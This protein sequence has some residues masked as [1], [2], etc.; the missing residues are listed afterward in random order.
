MNKQQ[1]STDGSTANRPNPYDMCGECGKRFCEVSPNCPH[2]IW[3]LHPL[4]ARENM[5]P[6]EPK[7]TILLTVKTAAVPII[8]ADLRTLV[9][10]GEIHPLT[11][12]MLFDIHHKLER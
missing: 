11:S 10:E 3:D 12:E 4:L 9:L 6:S 5:P 7:E 8:K 1:R 2:R